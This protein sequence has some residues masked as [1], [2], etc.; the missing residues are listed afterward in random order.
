VQ[1]NVEPELD[2]DQPRPWSRLLIGAIAGLSATAAMTAAMRRL[3]ARLPEREQ[4]PLPPREITETVAG[5]K[6]SE[7]V[8]RDASLAAHFAFGAATGALLAAAK[9]QPGMATGAAFGTA[10]W[11]ASY[12]GWVPG[13]D[14]L[15][16]ADEHPMRRNALMIAVH[17]LWGAATAQVI[18]ELGMA[19]ATMLAG[20]PLKDRKERS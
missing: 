12:F 11:T 9:K 1:Q 6:G 8:L 3:H 7:A 16:P 14:I 15:R 19:R 2:Q 20:G 10:V 4:Y 18:R 13:F 17:L 5:G